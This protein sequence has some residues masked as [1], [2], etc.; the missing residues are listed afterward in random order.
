MHTFCTYSNTNFDSVRGE[1]ELTEEVSFANCFIAIKSIFKA[2]LP[3]KSRTVN[4]VSLVKKS[5]SVLE[6]ENM[7]PTRNEEDL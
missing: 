3:T 4:E 1:K 7:F 6:V 2:F 5:E